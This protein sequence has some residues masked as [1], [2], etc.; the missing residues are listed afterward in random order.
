MNNKLLDFFKKD[1]FAMTNGIR[2]VEAKP[3]YAVAKMEI[4]DSHL[5]TVNIVQGGAIFT[6]A[7]HAFAAASNAGGLVTLSTSAH[8]S[9]FRPV[10]GVFSLTAIASAVSASNKICCYNVDVFDDD[11]VLVARFIGQGYIKKDKH[12]F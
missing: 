10:R 11:N 3:G 5:N 8:I 12:D 4:R 9:Y 2:L 1:R 6:L 7:D